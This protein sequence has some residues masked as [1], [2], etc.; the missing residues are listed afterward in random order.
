MEVR[1][2]DKL[3][4]LDIENYKPLR[5]IVFE[6]LRQSI[7]DGKLEPGKRLMEIQMAEQLGVSRTPIREAIRKLEL[8]GLVVM[9]PRKGAYVADVSIKDVL[10]VLE[11]RGVLEGLAASLAAERMTDDEIKDLTSIFNEFRACYENNDIEGLI[12]K[13]VE[14]HDCIFN[15]A[16]NA[17]LNQ[18]AQGLR[19]QIYRFRVRYIS[20]YNKAKELVDEHGNIF[21]AISNRDPE[22]AYK[23]GINHIEN[24]TNHM[25][26]QLQ[27]YK[28]DEK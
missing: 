1:K 7:L 26:E 27:I 17:K 28:E 20:R 16:R 6:Y 11:V 14:F 10:E 9:V 21:E 5:E 19:E 12:E 15:G 4:K 3:D 25:M 24:L 22:L 8:E 13:D 2:L 18:I 23:C